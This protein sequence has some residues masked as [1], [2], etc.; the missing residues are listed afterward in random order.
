[1]LVPLMISAGN[2]V[3]REIAGTEEPDSCKSR[4]QAEGVT[5]DCVLKGLGEDN[6]I[7][8]MFLER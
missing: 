3:K 7:Q 6:R 5:V 8:I 1:M 4:L 2:H